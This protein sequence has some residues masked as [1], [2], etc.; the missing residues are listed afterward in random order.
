VIGRTVQLDGAPTTIVGVIP[1]SFHGLSGVAEIF[2]P[3]AAIGREMLEGRWVH[4]MTVVARLDPS[5]GFERARAEM[6]VLGKRIDE[7]HRSP[8]D[9]GPWGADLKRLEELRIDP[10]IRRSLLVL[11]GA[12]AGYC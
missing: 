3:L 8:R 7:L 4:F 6:Q 1:A 11:F 2:V 10:A 12:V 9:A 5:V